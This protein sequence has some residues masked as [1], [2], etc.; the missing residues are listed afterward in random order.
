[1][2]LD[3][4][5]RFR[6]ETSRLV[7]DDENEDSDIEEESGRFYS[8]KQ[9]RQKEED[10]KRQAQEEFLDIEQG[11]IEHFS[12]T[13]L[14]IIVCLIQ[15]CRSKAFESFVFKV[16]NKIAVLLQKCFAKNSNRRTF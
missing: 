12:P 16:Y 10:S 14:Y 9:L 2:P 15:E 7:R 11:G 6:K 3:D 13:E 8:S 1:M 5:Q 4:T